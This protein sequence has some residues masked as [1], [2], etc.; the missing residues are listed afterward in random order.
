MKS[1]KKGQLPPKPNPRK[2]KRFNKA[3]LEA[4][5]N[6]PMVIRKVKAAEEFFSSPGYR[7]IERVSATKKKIKGVKKKPS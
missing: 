4:I 2:L 5:R 7:A 3:Q 1:K 6:S